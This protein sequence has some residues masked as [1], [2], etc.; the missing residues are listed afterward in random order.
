MM[1]ECAKKRQITAERPTVELVLKRQSTT[2]KTGSEMAKGVMKTYMPNKIKMRNWVRVR[3][4]RKRILSVHV[5]SSG[6][7][8]EIR[9]CVKDGEGRCRGG[10]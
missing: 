1:M 2:E 9:L 7:H 3:R 10:G 4:V 6:I 5:A 8:T